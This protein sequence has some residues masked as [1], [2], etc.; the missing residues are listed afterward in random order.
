MQPLGNFQK[1][2]RL[3]AMNSKYLGPANLVK[4]VSTALGELAGRLTIQR[5]KGRSHRILEIDGFA[6][7]DIR[8]AIAVYLVSLICQSVEA[9]L[10][11]REA[12]FDETTLDRDV[13]RDVVS[14]VGKKSLKSSV[15][16]T[17]RDPWIWEGICHLFIHLSKSNKKY[18]PTG[19][20][21][22]KTSVKYDV[23]DHGLDLIAIYKSDDLGISAGECKAYLRDPSRAI[24]HASLALGE[25]DANI[26][27]IEI[28]AAVTQLRPALS[29]ANQARIAGAFWRDERC[30]FPFV[31]CDLD[32]ARDWTKKRKSLSALK[33]PDD[34]KL[35]VPC[36]MKKARRAFDDIA[37]KMRVYSRRSDT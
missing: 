23:V 26:R 18:H 10:Q 32:F 24:Q 13:R 25:I 12:L 22:A 4:D 28:R 30:Y 37:K 3:L 14:V 33:V 9:N 11:V 29:S 17:R 34:K 19:S 7:R 31:C 21:L 8:D 36:S 6:D 20:I 35:L 16:T 27:D 15:K 2:L 5:K 1:C